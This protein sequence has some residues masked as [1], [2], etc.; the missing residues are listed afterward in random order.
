M[1]PGPIERTIHQPGPHPREQLAAGRPPGRHRTTRRS[2]NTGNNPDREKR[3]FFCQIEAF[4]TAI[5]LTEVAAIRR[6]PGSRTISSQANEKANPGLY[7]IAFKMATGS[8]KTVVMAMLIA[9]QTLNKLA[10]PRTP[11]S[12]T[13]SSWSRR[14]SPSATGYASSFPTTR[15]TTTASWTWCRPRDRLDRPRPPRPYLL[16]LA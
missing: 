9:W 16:R 12:P 6:R 10:N 1:D 15:T 8:G 7:R 11:G 3:L 14:A 5:Y 2:W 4:E 13:P